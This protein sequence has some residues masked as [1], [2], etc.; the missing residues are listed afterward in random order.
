MTNTLD[1]IGSGW[2]FPLTLHRGG[3][4]LTQHH[5]EEIVQAILIILSTPIGSRLMRPEFGCRIHELLFAPINVSTF[6]AAARYVEEALGYWEP[7]IDVLDVQVR[8]DHGIKG[9]MRVHLTYHIRA[10]HDERA[11]VFPF[12]S[13]PE[14]G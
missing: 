2:H 3:I 12:Y 8:S 7:R 13:I 14:E 4:A 1:I 5:D 6:A 10:T 9:C 11:L